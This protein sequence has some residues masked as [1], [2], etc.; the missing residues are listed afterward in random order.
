MPF[1]VSLEKYEVDPPYFSANTRSHRS[2]E[3]S[4]KYQS[5]TP[6]RINKIHAGR[7][8]PFRVIEYRTLLASSFKVKNKLEQVMARAKS[9]KRLQARRKMAKNSRMCK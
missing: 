7:Q 6:I 5:T 2:S 1:L 4:L 9:I 8:L 3:S